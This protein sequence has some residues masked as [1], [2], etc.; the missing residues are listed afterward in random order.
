[1]KFQVLLITSVI[2]LFYFV[3]I[4]HRNFQLIS[5]TASRNES[6]QPRQ[7]HLLD[8]SCNF[9]WTE[10]M[11]NSLK[12]RL[13][14]P[15][16]AGCE[17]YNIDLF[18]RYPAT[19][20]FSMKSKAHKNKLECVAQ[21]LKGGL[22]PDYSSFQLGKTQ[23]FYPKLNKRFWVNANNFLITCYSGQLVIYRKQFMGLKMDDNSKLVVDGSFEIPDPDIKV[24][25][26][27]SKQFSI[28]ILGLDSTSRAQ[29]GRHMRKTSDLLNR[30]G[31]VVFE[32]YNKVGDNS[33][34]NML[35]ILADELSETENLPLLDET[36]DVNINKILSFKD[37]SRSR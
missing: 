29:F 18:K 23:T 17:K 30:L 36:G 6:L 22:K 3:F 12:K 16:R 21:V 35:Q 19:G 14:F 37:T 13:K 9:L 27:D 26:S 24:Q 20:E 2:C 15:K 25:R 7:T 32:A 31:S 5:E 33:A 28:S 8:N 1:M 10:P 11:D 34:V 4:S